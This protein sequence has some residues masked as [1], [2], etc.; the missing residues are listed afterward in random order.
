MATSKKRA[1]KEAHPGEPWLWKQSWAE[2]RIRTSVLSSVVF[3]IF[4]TGVWSA[5]CLPVAYMVFWRGEVGADD[6]MFWW[7]SLALTVTNFFLILWAVAAVARWLKYGRSFFEMASVPGVIGGQLAGVVCSS[8]KIKAQGGFR[9]KLSCINSVSPRNSEHISRNILWEKEQLIAH[10]MLPKDSRQTAIPI[11]F[12]IPYECRSTDETDWRDMVYWQLEVA[13]E[14]AGSD[15]HAQFQ[16]PVFRTP[17]SDPDFVID[18]S[19]I[20]QYVAPVDDERDLRKAKVRRT[21]LPTGDGQQF[22]FPMARQWK[23]AILVTLF[24]VL[25]LGL[26]VGLWWWSDLGG[27]IWIFSAVSGLVGF[28]TAL[29]AVNLWFYKS[30]IEVSPRGLAVTGGL[31]GIGRRRWV[32]EE[33]LVEIKKSNNFDSNGQ[34]YYDL[35]VVCLDDQKITAGKYIPGDRLATSIIRQIEQAMGRDGDQDS[36]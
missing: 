13:A 30:K 4:F 15:Y 12:Q 9:I 33:E 10:G 8:S 1:L 6:W 25:F 27:G 23:G 11:L 2:G 18:E 21:P 34:K 3:P 36:S 31:F 32:D 5:I 29:I 16:V 17:Q 19:L 28:V 14:T 35:I 22:S 7:I 20:S 24:A 26:P